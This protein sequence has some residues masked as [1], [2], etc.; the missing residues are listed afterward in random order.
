[1]SLR[2][3]LKNRRLWSKL[4]SPLILTLLS[5]FHLSHFIYTS[6]PL[7][8][9]PTFAF[10]TCSLSHFRAFALS[11]FITSLAKLI[12]YFSHSSQAHTTYIHLLN[13]Y[14]PH[15]LSNVT[16]GITIVLLQI[17]VVQYVHAFAVT[18]NVNEFYKTIYYGL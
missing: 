10:Y 3:K 15:L 12:F 6:A 17:A 9:Y 13:L 7:S 11:H 2:D 16:L 5:H 4:S 18:A 14:Q 1:M 8:H